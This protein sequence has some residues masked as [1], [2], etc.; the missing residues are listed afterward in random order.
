VVFVSAASCAGGISAAA[1][2]FC[3][4]LVVNVDD[5]LQMLCTWGRRIE[6]KAKRTPLKPKK[7]DFINF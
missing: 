3:A 7:L 6:F 5:P 2:I 4:S 1:A